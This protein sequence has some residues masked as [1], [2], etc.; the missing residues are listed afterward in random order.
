[1]NMLCEK[2]GGVKLQDMLPAYKAF[3]ASHADITIVQDLE[4]LLYTR[5]RELDQAGAFFLQSG[6][7]VSGYAPYFVQERPL[8]CFFGELKL[9]ELPLRCLM[10]LGAPHFPEDEQAYALLFE[11][12]DKFGSDI[13]GIFAI[14]LP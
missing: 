1:M 5:K 9:A 4:W 13:D 12:V 8:R 3:K 14:G 6:I 11:E 7:E 10:L 2:V